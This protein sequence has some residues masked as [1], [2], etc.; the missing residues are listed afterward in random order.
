MREITPDKS[1]SVYEHVRFTWTMNAQPVLLKNS[2]RSRPQGRNGDYSL[3]WISADC[4]FPTPC[5][6]RSC[7]TGQC[8]ACPKSSD[9][10]QAK[11]TISRATVSSC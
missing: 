4:R 2:T 9:C 10:G 3:K 1:A 8:A 6:V 7:G 11:R 5:L